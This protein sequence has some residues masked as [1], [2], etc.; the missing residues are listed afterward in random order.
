MFKTVVTAAAL[1]IIGA[2]AYFFFGEYQQFEAEKRAKTQAFIRSQ[3]HFFNQCANLITEASKFKISNPEHYKNISRTIDFERC[4][5]SLEITQKELLIEEA[6]TAAIQSIHNST[7]SVCNTHFDYALS[8]KAKFPN[9]YQKVIASN[10]FEK[11]LTNLTQTFCSKLISDTEK[12]KDF[13]PNRYS[14]LVGS[15]HYTRCKEALASQ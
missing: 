5:T 8:I 2:T 14:V 4:S 6:R 10:E 12:I 9:S 7:Q 11:C 13:N 1:C 3:I 15:A